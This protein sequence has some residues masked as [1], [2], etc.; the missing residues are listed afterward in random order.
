MLIAFHG[1]AA[2][3]FCRDFLLGIGYQLEEAA[4][5]DAHSLIAVDPRRRTNGA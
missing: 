2:R 1:D 4:E 5:I 3:D